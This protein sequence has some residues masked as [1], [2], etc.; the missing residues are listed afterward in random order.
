ME[1]MTIYDACRSVPETAKKAITA[2][3]LKGK[4]D[5]NPMWRIK[6]LTEQFGPCGIG[7]Y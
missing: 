3:R 1:N 7:W 6:R 5:I 4:T 2:G